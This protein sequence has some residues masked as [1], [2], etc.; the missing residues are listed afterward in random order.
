MS[1][2]E[3]QVA[4]WYHEGT[5]HPFGALYNRTYRMDPGQ[6]PL[7]YKV[8]TGLEARP[9][10]LDPSPRGVPAL[11][12][13]ATDPPGVPDTAAGDE[14][15]LPDLATLSRLLYFSGGIT[16][17]LRSSRGTI[18]FRAAAC[19]GALYHIELYLVAGD[20]PGLQAGV[21]HFD[22]RE[23]ALRR[24]RAGDYRQILVEASGEEPAVR[25]APAI[26]VMTDVV[27]R[28]AYKYR[29]RAY[30]HAFWDS[31]TILANLL[32]TAT[33]HGLPAN[34]VAGFVDRTVA[35]LL[36]LDPARELALVLVPLGV[37]HRSVP[38]APASAALH[39]ETL[40]VRA[41]DDLFP[42]IRTVHEASSLPSPEAV[43][44][45]RGAGAALP[46]SGG[47]H[48]PGAGAAGA[49]PLQPLAGAELPAVDVET[50]IVRRGST[51]RFAR[52][53]ISFQQLST[54]LERCLRAAPA[55][56]ATH[57]GAALYEVY[58]IVNAVDGLEPGTYAWRRE[59]GA[60][61]RLQAGEHR[62]AAGHL[63]LDQDLA[64]D[65]A[66]N[67]YFLA[68][69]Q[70]V[71]ER[72]GERGYRAAQ[73]DAA[74]AAGRM[75]LAAYGL[76]FGATGLTFYDDEV[77]AFFGPPAT[78]KSVLFLMACGRPARRRRR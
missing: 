73:L 20:L 40:P 71:L 10:P 1:D 39:L 14:G 52:R 12:A 77:T 22:P 48:E 59:N 68:D 3:A 30:R 61:Q 23:T 36:E 76:G 35:Q 67:V 42:A 47:P 9:L 17:Q 62:E 33:A 11:T 53:A 31:G 29:E 16:K 72:L 28:N 24:L 4:R 69:L 63:A 38:P 55:D 34:V 64:A 78:G 37:S 41:Y 7:L 8:Y 51:R 58:L 5:K 50:V 27:W 45:W 46:A 6:R 75:Y 54:I 43:A 19:T 44:A 57:P 65:A 26:L 74:I 13:V 32:A 56:F 18:P 66:V 70:P 21:Y 15:Q 2:G 60:L 49:V 25:Q